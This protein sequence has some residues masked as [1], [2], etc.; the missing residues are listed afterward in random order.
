[1]GQGQGNVGEEKRDVSTEAPIPD[2]ADSTLGRARVGS[3]AN[4]QISM[5]NILTTNKKSGAEAPQGL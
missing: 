1:M 4:L 2:G 3:R 5:T